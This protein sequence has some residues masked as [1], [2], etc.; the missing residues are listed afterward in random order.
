MII[1]PFAPKMSKTLKIVLI[2][3]ISL[4]VLLAGFI[5]FY[6]KIISVKELGDAYLNIFYTNLKVKI[7]SHIISFVLIFS[8]FY[9][10]TRIIEK[11]E[12]DR[13]GI[14]IDF[15]DKKG[16]K[17]IVSIVL[18]I[19]A[20]SYVS[21]TIYD[22]FLLFANRTDFNMQDPIFGKDIGYY[23]FT[24]P[25]LAAL[26]NSILSVWFVVLIYTLAIY[27]MIYAINDYYDISNLLED[28]KAIIH[29]L[30]N[31]VIY[32]LLK[33]F[34]YQFKSEEILYSSFNGFSGAG[35]TDIFVWFNFYKFAPFFL[36]ALVVIAL[37][38][39]FK[40]KYKALIITVLVYPVVMIAVTITSFAVQGLIVKPN[41]S[42]KEKP[43]LEH[44]INFTKS[45]YNIDDVIEIEF[46]ATNN[47]TKETIDKNADILSNVRITD[48]SS[49]LTAYNSLQGIRDF[50]RFNDLN[51]SKYNI[52][53]T[54]TLVMLAP[55]EVN[56]E[57]LDANS[58]NYTNSTYRYT[59]GFGAVM[60]PQ[61]RVTKEGQ[62]DFLISNI[63]P[64]SNE[65]VVDIKQPRIYYGSN[66]DGYVVVN[67]SIKEIDYID[68]DVNKEFS[69]DGKGGIK[70]NFLNKLAFSL[71]Y[72]DYHM[73]ISDYLTP[74]SRIILNRNVKARAEQA[75]PFLKFD[76]P[77]FVV[78][79]NGY[80]KWIIDGYTTSSYYPYSQ[81]YDGINYIRN[82]V[83][84]VI[85]AYDGTIDAYIIDKNDPI[86]KSYAK[87]YP[88]VFKE[89]ELPK[90]LTDHIVYPEYLFKLQATVYAKYH[91][92]N[93]TTLYNN[94]DFWVFSKEKY[95]TELRDI[96]PYY[97]ML[98]IDEFTHTDNNFVIMIPY[99]LKNKENM[100]SWLAA[101]CDDENYGQMVVYK[102]PK[103]KN[104]YGTQ[105]IES[106]I[107]NDPQISKEMTL[108]GQGGSTVIRGNTL[109]VPI[110]SSLL[111][112]EPVYIT[113]QNGAGLP[114][115]KRVIVSY[116]DKVV[117]EDTLSLALEKMFRNSKP[118]GEENS[119]TNPDDNVSP[120]N[121]NPPD[122]SI[123]DEE[124]MVIIDNILASYDDADNAKK[125]GNWETFGQSMDMLDDAIEELEIYR[126]SLE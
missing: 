1:Q 75:L 23:I 52:D 4:F 82:S 73:L 115:L 58:K 59:H 85:D 93:A 120:E 8:F 15:M 31:I 119:E 9:I 11:F 32:F 96:E 69:Y 126:N 88:G 24:R 117:M 43:Y 44:N 71:R 100:T 19:F 91:V 99:T 65:G 16:I 90:S 25:F 30:I 79:D 103:G 53:G 26:V 39:F 111:Y 22:T 56:L 84:V 77:N 10:S 46:P 76:E 121:Q 80:L 17:I 109:V 18:A 124:L 105:Q 118:S 5:T 107:D 114:E 62:P 72:L 33:A 95:G 41:E 110:E 116:G 48:F 49:T 47:L 74:D 7:I 106:K 123:S 81:T 2:S 27:I 14:V 125:E 92:N 38:F 13:T 40:S 86:I 28:K 78:D 60:S 87:M 42:I 51:V 101:S 94:S 112:I 102:F 3:V 35:Y 61:N 108:W 20:S 55:R 37:I 12:K 67:S 83:K 36:L 113:S 21:E 54:P 29:N 97:N 34:T 66:M 98:K 64:K 89:G 6:T 104:V 45:A 68:G 122:V 70:L 63:P 50:Y 57:H